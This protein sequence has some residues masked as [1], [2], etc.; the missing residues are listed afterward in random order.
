[1][2]KIVL[3]ITL[4]LSQLNL[5]SQ[6]QKIKPCFDIH[7]LITY[8]KIYK[9]NLGFSKNIIAKGTDFQIF[10]DFI[11]IDYQESRILEHI[12]NDNE[13][14]I[15]KEIGLDTG[16]IGDESYFY[17]YE[18]SNIIDT[19]STINTLIF[20]KQF[21]EYIILAEVYLRDISKNFTLSSK[22]KGIIELKGLDGFDIS[23]FD[24]IN[25]YYLFK[26][27]S[28]SGLNYLGFYFEAHLP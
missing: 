16:Q 28:E 11:Y 9:Y 4:I 19:S 14:F 10:D 3:L 22:I 27:D 1:M 21:N 24:S 18:L 26:C 17:F 23:Y 25:R 15:R 13:N 7:E 6:Q 5:N 8:T 20:Y 2:K 12:K